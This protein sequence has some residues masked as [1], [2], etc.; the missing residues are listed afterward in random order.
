MLKEFKEFAMKGNVLDMAVGIII[1][2]AFTG[3]VNSLVTDII[4]P[5]MGGKVMAEW[6]KTTNPHLKILFTSGYTDNSI[7]H[8]GTLDPG[9]AFIAKPYTP[10][11]LA[12]K[13][14]EM[15][16]EIPT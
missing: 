15:L 16:D 7:V 3:I 1:G 12:R 5:Q 6:L 13:V 9:V 4:M 11:N 2:A 14:R 8:D 10:T